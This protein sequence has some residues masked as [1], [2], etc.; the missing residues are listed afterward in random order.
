MDPRQVKIKDNSA[1]VYRVIRYDLETKTEDLDYAFAVQP[2][3]HTT[4]G[5]TFLVQGQYQLPLFKGKPPQAI[6]DGQKETIRELKDCLKKGQIEPLDHVQLI[7]RLSFEESAEQFAKQWF[8]QVQP[9]VNLMTGLIAPKKVSNYVLH[10]SHG[11]LE[12][13]TDRLDHTIEDF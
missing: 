13:R 5:E 8:P 11:K 6:L 3:V 1:I 12:L 4:Q 10:A 9:Q 2:L 7:S